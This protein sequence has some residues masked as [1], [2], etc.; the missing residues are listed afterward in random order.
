MTDW[1]RCKKCG[2]ATKIYDEKCPDCGY[3]D[4]DWNEEVDWE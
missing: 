1:E 4:D 3:D 2:F